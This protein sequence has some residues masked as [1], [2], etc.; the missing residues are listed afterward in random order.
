M[1]FDDNVTKFTANIQGCPKSK[2]C[3][4]SATSDYSVLT[5]TPVTVFTCNSVN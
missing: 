1:S 2:A 4:T 5:V 3:I